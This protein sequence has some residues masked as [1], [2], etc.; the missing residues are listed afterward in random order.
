[1]KNFIVVIATIVILLLGMAA[2]KEMNRLES[3]IIALKKAVNKHVISL[4][5]KADKAEIQAVERQLDEYEKEI[6]S[7]VF[8]YKTLDEILKQIGK[9]AQRRYEKQ[10]TE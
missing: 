8:R 3:E 9:E 6:D 5:E 10:Y 4:H 1:M 2:M 7:M